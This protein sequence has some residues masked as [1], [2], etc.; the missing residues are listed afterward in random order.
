MKDNCLNHTRKQIQMEVDASFTYLNLAAHFSRDTVNMPG[1]AKLFFEHATEERSHALGLLNYLLM[2][3]PVDKH[4]H[5]VGNILKTPVSR[6]EVEPSLVSVVTKC[7]E[8]CFAPQ[9]HS[10]DRE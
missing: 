3:G 8:F 7:T 4:L 1:F 9:H 5:Q 10:S 2:R 6:I